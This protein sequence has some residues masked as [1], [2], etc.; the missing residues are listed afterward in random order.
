MIL[1]KEQKKSSLHYEENKILIHKYGGSECNKYCGD[2]TCLFIFY[3][4]YL[5]VCEVAI[6]TKVQI[7]IIIVLWRK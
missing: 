7:I 5:C 2:E 3:F 1:T 4:L 6:L